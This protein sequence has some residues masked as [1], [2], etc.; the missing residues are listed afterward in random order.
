MAVVA[1]RPGSLRQ[2]AALYAGA[3]R[4]L[5][6]VVYGDRL[7][8]AREKLTPFFF[9]IG[10]GLHHAGRAFVREFGRDLIPGESLG[11]DEDRSLSRSGTHYGVHFP[12][13]EGGALADY[14]RALFYAFALRCAFLSLYLVVAAL[15]VS[16]N[17]EVFVCESEEDPLL[18]ITVIGVFALDLR[19]EL[20]PLCLDFSQHGLRAVLLD[21]V[22]GFYIFSEAVIVSD[23]QVGAFGCKVGPVLHF[24]EV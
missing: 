4:K 19:V 13:P 8:H 5:A 14:I 21:C 16:L 9:Q 24:A 23:F 22:L 12:V 2:Y 6:A 15:L 7:A 3:V 18:D 11:Q 10:E 17:R 1:L 20:E